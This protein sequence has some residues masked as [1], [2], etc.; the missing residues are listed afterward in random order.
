MMQEKKKILT[1]E[2]LKIQSINTYSISK[3]NGKANVVY[4]YLTVTPQLD[5]K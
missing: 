2:N 5:L 1:L 4:A 3:Y